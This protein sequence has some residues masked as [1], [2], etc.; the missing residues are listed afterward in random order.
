[1]QDCDT[2]DTI[3]EITPQKRPATHLAFTRRLNGVKFDAMCI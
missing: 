1:M 3:L 2:I